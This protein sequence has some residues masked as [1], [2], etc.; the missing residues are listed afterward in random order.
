MIGQGMP[1]Y[2]IGLTILLVADGIAWGY[3]LYVLPPSRRNTILKVTTAVWALLP[4][5]AG[6]FFVAIALQG[7]EAAMQAWE[8]SATRDSATLREIAAGPSW[9]VTQ[10]MMRYAKYY[11]L[12]GF[13]FLALVAC[14][15]I[16]NDR[17]ANRYLAWSISLPAMLLW[18]YVTW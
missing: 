12:L 4:L 14:W 15:P 9:L 7:N 16:A 8:V 3:A 1:W 5:A 17:T 2:E 6:L 10:E 13:T 18:L 11:L